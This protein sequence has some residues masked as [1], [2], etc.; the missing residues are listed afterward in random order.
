[1]I[2]ESQKIA[3]LRCSLSTKAAQVIKNRYIDEY[4]EI[5]WE[6]LRENGLRPTSNTNHMVLLTEENKRLKAALRQQG[7]EA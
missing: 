2:T 7:V 6:L 3:R 1:M 4:Q 5:Y